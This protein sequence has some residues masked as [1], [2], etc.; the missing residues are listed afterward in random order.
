M[1][2]QMISSAQPDLLQ[3]PIDVL[4]EPLTGEVVDLSRENSQRTSQACT[5]AGCSACALASEIESS[6][7]HPR[8]ARTQMPLTYR[9]D[10]DVAMAVTM[11]MD[12][13]TDTR[14]L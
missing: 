8:R 13:D 9:L 14:R 4:L 11:D 1:R 5:A 12:M 10:M 3:P 6:G 7:G 2:M